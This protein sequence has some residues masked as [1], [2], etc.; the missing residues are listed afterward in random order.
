MASLLEPY[1]TGAL[2][3]R[4]RVVQSATVTNLGRNDRVTDAQVAFYA[5]RA[6]GG[7]GLVITEGLAV[8]P[9]SIPTHTVPLAYDERLVPEFEKLAEAVH[10]EGARILGQLWHAGRQALWNPMQLP[11]SA[12]SERRGT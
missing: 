9:S 12:S 10:C 5:E 7:V 4:N 6:A 2:S 8:H 1:T 11:W 3:L